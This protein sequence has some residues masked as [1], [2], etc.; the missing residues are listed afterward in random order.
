MT[1]KITLLGITL[2]FISVGISAAITYVVTIPIDQN[3]EELDVTVQEM[4]ENVQ[5]LNASLGEEVIPQISELEKRI[6][7]LDQDSRIPQAFLSVGF[8]CIDSV[9]NVS[10]S[11]CMLH[12]RI[13]DETIISEFDA[14]SG[15]QERIVVPVSRRLIITANRAGYNTATKTF[16]Y[17][18]NGT[19]QSHDIELEK[20]AQ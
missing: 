13:Q 3:I 8:T 12:F 5:T 1:T 6:N 19:F 17:V 11:D 15:N 7:A 4:G 16:E 18:E 20:T 9:S 2:I 10:L 14:E